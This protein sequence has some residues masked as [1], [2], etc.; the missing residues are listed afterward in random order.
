MMKD[1]SGDLRELILFTLQDT[2][3]RLAWIE[4]QLCEEEESEGETE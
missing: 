2:M 4:E 1:L 3:K